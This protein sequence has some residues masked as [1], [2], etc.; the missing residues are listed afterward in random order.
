MAS[1]DGCKGFRAGS[2]VEAFVLIGARARSIAKQSL[3][4]WPKAFGGDIVKRDGQLVG[5]HVGKSRKLMLA[6]RE[7]LRAR[8]AAARQASCR[9][10]PMHHMR[11]GRGNWPD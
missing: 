3:R 6:S 4:I 7:R 9:H 1:G 5:E 2:K 8:E 11:Q 10:S